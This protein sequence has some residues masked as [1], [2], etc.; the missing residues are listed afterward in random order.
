[1][2]VTYIQNRC[3]VSPFVTP[4]AWGWFRNFDW[5]GVLIARVGKPVF[6]V[7]KFLALL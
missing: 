4:A 3:F 2:G 5:A 1:M 7:E 6:V